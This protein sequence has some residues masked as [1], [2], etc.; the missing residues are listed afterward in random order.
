MNTNLYNN[1]SFK[2]ISFF[3]FTGISISYSQNYQWVKQFGAA[4]GGDNGVSIAVD[5][6]KNVYTTGAFQGIVDFDP[7]AEVH[8]LSSPGGVDAYVS[9]ADG[10]GNYIWAKKISG[11]Y[12]EYGKSIKVGASGNVYVTGYFNGIISFDATHSL[13]TTGGTGNDIFV[14]SYTSDGDVR[15]AKKFGGTSD[16]GGIDLAIDNNENVYVTGFYQG[17]NIAFDSH[18]ITSFY[19][20]DPNNPLT[21]INSQDIFICKLNSDGNVSW[22]K[23]FGGG[24]TY[25]C[26][27]G[28]AVDES[29]VYISTSISYY[30]HDPNIYEDSDPSKLVATSAGMIDILVIKL[31]SAGSKVWCNQM[32]GPVHDSP[33]DIALD[34]ESNVYITGS[35]YNGADFDP[36]GSTF[37]LPTDAYNSFVSEYDK[38][39]VFITATALASN[40]GAQNVDGIVGNS[41][42]VYDNS[43]TPIVYVT[44]HFQGTMDFA[45][46][47]FTCT[48]GIP[49][50]TDIFVC[51][52][53]N[54][55]TVQYGQQI[56]SGDSEGGHGIATDNIGDQYITGDFAG[57][58]DFDPLGGYVP[59]TPPLFLGLYTYTDIFDLKLTQTPVPELTSGIVSTTSVNC[60]GNNTGAATATVAGGT[61]AYTYNWML[62][63]ITTINA[64]GLYV[65]N[66]TF[67]VK[68]AIGCTSTNTVHIIEPAAIN[69]T[70]V[71]TYANCSSSTRGIATVTSLSGGTTPY[72][73]L[74]SNGKTTSSVTGLTVGTYSITVSDANNCSLVRIAIISGTLT[75][76][77]A[78]TVSVSC[79]G[80]NTGST[81]AST[82]GGVSPY[83]YSWSNGQT[84]NSAT[85]L[86]AGTYTLLT[87][88]A[89]GCTTRKT[90]TITQPASALNFSAI[91]T[92]VSCGTGGST[93]RAAVT[94]TGGTTTYTYLW[95]NGQTKASATG[96]AAAIYTI[97]V[98]DKN[99]CTKTNTVAITE[100]SNPSVSIVSTT[101]TSC[102]LGNN[103]TAT[104]LATGGTGTY[105]YTWNTTGKTTELATGLSS[106]T[107][108]ITVRDGNGCSATQTTTIAQPTQIGIT[109]L[110][111][112]VPIVCGQDGSVSAS[113]AS[114]GTP[115]YTYQWQLYNG[116]SWQDFSPAQSSNTA[117][118]TIA[119]ALAGN[120]GIQVLKVTDSR[121]CTRAGQGTAL[122]YSPPVTATITIS[123]VS[124]QGGNNGSATVSA[125]GGYGYTGNNSFGSFKG[126]KYTYNWSN[127]K[128]TATVTGLS[129]GV[130]TVTVIST[131]TAT[132]TNPAPCST[133]ITVTITEPSAITATITSTGVSC[134]NGSASVSASGGTPNYTYNWNNGQ[135]SITA[136]DLAVGVYTVTVVDAN[137]CTKIQTTTISATS[138]TCSASLTIS[139]GSSTSYSSP[140][141]G[142]IAI[143]G[144][145]T[146]N[147]NFTMDACEAL[148]G[149]DAQIVINSGNTLTINN[150]SHL[151]ACGDMWTGIEIQAGGFLVIVN[152]IIEDAITA[153]KSIGGAEYT[154]SGSSFNKN[155][156]GIFVDTYYGVHLGSVT[157]TTFTCWT[158]ST[159]GTPTTISKC[160]KMGMRSNTGIYLNSV[161][162]D[163]FSGSSYTP[164]VKIIDN[165]VF[166]NLDYGVYAFSSDFI[167]E[168]CKFKNLIGI[169]SNTVIGTGIYSDNQVSTTDV[170]NFN[171]NN[172][173]FNEVQNGIIL[174]G[175]SFY[176][177]YIAYNVISNSSS[178]TTEN[179]IANRGIYYKSD[180]D[181]DVF[182]PLITTNTVINT[183]KAIE[184]IVADGINTKEVDVTNNTIK[185]SLS[186]FISEFGI[187]YEEIDP[188]LPL[189]THRL[190]FYNTIEGK[191]QT[192]CNFKN[193]GGAV[194][195][196]IGYN[197]INLNNISAPQ[198]A[199]NIWDS[200]NMQV[201][202]NEIYLV[203]P[204]SQTDKKGITINTSPYSIIS[205][206]T[207]ENFGV[208][209]YIYGDVYGESPQTAITCNYMDVCYYGVYLENVVI[210][211]QG[212]SASPSDNKWNNMQSGGLNVYAIS[213]TP[214]S[215]YYRGDNSSNLALF[216]P[217]IIGTTTVIITAVSVTTT[218]SASCE[219][220]FN[221]KGNDSNADSATIKMKVFE[222]EPISGFKLYPNPNNGNI[223]IEYDLT[224]I[225]KAQLD[226][227][228]ITGILILSYELP[229]DK[230]KLQINTDDLLNGIYLYKVMVNGKI[231]QNNKLVIIK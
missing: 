167:V 166:D 97:T 31:T 163:Y 226:V 61:G 59:L 65:G 227:Y 160:P 230:S 184:V 175:E 81:L 192:G 17:V 9:K 132:P 203:N 225:D 190:F 191:I 68:D 35:Y 157:T 185:T 223:N 79:N 201:V 63:G 21:D 171:A 188:A 186:D 46:V 189:L 50:S 123:A 90:V 30:Q 42:S 213:G 96:L 165:N 164:S 168:N 58:A 25:D 84:A 162:F 214:F 99:G 193:V 94:L 74:W 91:T 64:T 200:Y 4:N 52:L 93:G 87:T 38:D 220:A 228:D 224:D 88:D 86:V 69:Y 212:G 24:S 19:G 231:N 92:T 151:H 44:G 95:S 45:G 113:V 60:Y 53:D 146:I 107:Y 66:Y 198:T 144:V 183:Y 208:G 174:S 195:F 12:S 143:N 41:I 16:D 207:I 209:V 170:T 129:V 73:Y 80:G 85:G 103:G 138:T 145:F 156:E 135:T 100:A 153:V 117:S 122:N 106:R 139:G 114:G 181:E 182:G 67:T 102:Y 140:L 205:N 116:T 210:G 221:K 56:G 124:C 14:C 39:G 177:P 211:D 26:G 71:V 155:Y 141:S 119:Q 83:T 120:G 101:S 48:S 118:L 127:G 5:A 76:T 150:A 34:N 172:C 137:G 108:T 148:M 206:N 57:T 78:N 72:T 29:N 128:T 98:T 11:D 82:S 179:P 169:N 22:A 43:G 142:S 13:T 77:F 215:W 55:L 133:V 47:P 37:N 7:S 218:G 194:F 10:C 49:A 125:S 134:V 199:I 20:P 126:N 89:L 121:G 111:S 147:S 187:A 176:F 197:I 204:S 40:V 161:Y 217:N 104:A 216:N 222:K 51:K 18:T 219:T 110:Y 23:S 62:G 178:G 152:S 36:S 32:G 136:T 15:W 8:T 115:P 158:T 112:Y 3:L 149:K 54:N 229:A 180:L 130:Y 75:N 1:I 70:T 159:S 2:V 131:N 33:T 109:S 154:I 27:T 173:V 202:N 196:H 6:S 28:I 105:T